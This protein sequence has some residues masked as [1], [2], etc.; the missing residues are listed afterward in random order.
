MPDNEKNTQNIAS[1]QDIM[2]AL[3]G[4]ILD[5]T[6]NKRDILKAAKLLAKAVIN[7]SNSAT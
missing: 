5:K 3:A 7:K 4:I 6:A 2:I 1:E